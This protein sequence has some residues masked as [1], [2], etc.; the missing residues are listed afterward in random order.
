MYEGLRNAKPGQPDALT[1]ELTPEQ[2]KRRVVLKKTNLDNTGI[3]A[4]FLTVGAWLGVGGV[5]GGCVWE[6][7]GG[8]QR[9]GGGL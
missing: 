6:R 3:R 4:N 7:Q 8:E 5:G 9:A 1:R 2:K